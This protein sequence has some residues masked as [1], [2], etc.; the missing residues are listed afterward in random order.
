M[1][2]RGTPV[3]KQDFL[4]EH[5]GDGFTTQEGSIRLNIV[6]NHDPEYGPES[7]NGGCLGKIY[8]SLHAADHKRDSPFSA[9]VSSH[10]REAASQCVDRSALPSAN[11]IF[12]E[13]T[14]ATGVHSLSPEFS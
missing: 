8:L 10:W 9:Q 13:N 4:R 2:L 14:I 12:P 7:E 3:R 6:P 1:K 11:N 5:L